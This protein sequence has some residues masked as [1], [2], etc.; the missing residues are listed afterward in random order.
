M[1]T[2]S[3]HALNGTDG[4]HAGGI[5]VTLTNLATGAVVFV[6]KMDDGGRLSQIIAADTIDPTATY[7]LVFETGAYWVA[8]ATPASV[9]QIVLRFM[10]PDP[11]KTYHMPVIFNPNAY[12]MWSSS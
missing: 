2:L 6:S 1:A 12:S 9:N 4:T 7:V 8:R 11:N 3:S 5:A 10:M